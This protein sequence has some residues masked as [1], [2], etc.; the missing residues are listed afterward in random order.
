MSLIVFPSHISS[1]LWRGLLAGGCDFTD[2]SLHSCVLLFL[3]TMSGFHDAAGKQVVPGM[4][5]MSVRDVIHVLQGV[6]C[7]VIWRLSEEGAVRGGSANWQARVGVTTRIHVS[8][9]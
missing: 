7:V 2:D 6:C 4:G 9:T 1:W 8:N 3:N 5:R